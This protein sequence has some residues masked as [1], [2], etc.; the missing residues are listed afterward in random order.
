[1]TEEERD[2]QIAGQRLL[3]GRKLVIVAVILLLGVV[4]VSQLTT[5]SDKRALSTAATKVQRQNEQL[6]DNVDDLTSQLNCRNSINQRLDVARGNAEAIILFGL[7]HIRTIQTTGNGDWVNR[8]NKA[9]AELDSA[10]AARDK[11][12]ETCPTNRA[13]GG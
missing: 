7:L 1:M 13:Q 6:Q 2:L 4:L 8:A 12:D 10:I 9:L 11:T 3:A 5:Y